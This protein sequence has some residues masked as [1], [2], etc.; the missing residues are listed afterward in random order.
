M[1]EGMLLAVA[2]K[3]IEDLGSWAFQEIGSLWDVEA[4]LE[5]IKNT[6]ST[7]QAVLRDAAEQ[8]THS[9]QVKDWLE[10]LKD[11]VYEADDLLG[12]FYTEALQQGGI[13]GNIAKKVRG[14]FSTSNPLVLRREMSR[15][16][17]AMKQKLNA[18]A[19]DRK[20]F[21]L[22]EYNVGPPV[23]M[24]RE[25]TH[26]FVL[27]EKV[28]GREDDK[29]AIIKLLLEPNNEENVS[30]VPIVGIGGLGKTT[31]AQFVYNDKNIQEHFEL[32]MWICISDVFDV[33]MIIQKIVPAPDMEHVDRSMDELQDQLRKII[34][35]KKY[36]LVLDD[37]WNEDPHKWDSLKDLLVGGAKGSKIVI[38]TRARLV[39]EITC[40]T[41]IY[42]L[43]GLNEVQ[44][45]LLFKQIAFRKGQGQGTNN[46]RLEEIGREIV[47]KCQGIPLAI[48]SIGNVLRLE[49][50]EHKWLYVNNNILE[51]ATQQKNDIFPIL[52][53]SYDYLP[54]HLKSC[55]AFCS[56][57]PKDY[58]INKV[59]LVQLW[60]AQGFIRPSNKNQELEDVADEY[61]KDLLWRSFFEEVTNEK[62][63]LKYKMH[64]LIHD[65]A[66]LVARAECTIITLDRNN[67][68]EKTRHVSLPFYIGS[69]FIETLGL[70]VRAEK[71]RTC[72]L[73]FKPKIPLGA[74]YL[75]E[76][77][78]NKLFLSFRK[79]RALGLCGVH[80]E[81]VPDSI[82][83]LIHLT[84]LDFS[85]NPRI[86]TLPNAISRLWK[87][88]T[89]KFNDCQK[90]KELP[91]DIRFLVGLRH[92]ENSSC[93][94][95][96]HMP[97]GLG[98]MTCLQTLS[99]F[100]VRDN[101]ASTSGPI[102]SGLDELNSLNSLRGKLQIS[103]LRCLEDV[104]SEPNAA[105]L[106]AKQYLD[107]LSLLWHAND[108][109]FCSDDDNDGDEKLLEGLQPH[110]NLKFL[111]VNGYGGVRFSSWLSLLTNLVDLSITGC[112]RCQQ[113]PRLSQLH[114]LERL[115]LHKMEVLE[116]IS[117]GDINEEV[118]TSSF[119]P[120]LKSIFIH[121]CPKLKGWWRSS[122]TTDHQQ[123]PHHQSLPSFHH[124]S[125]L[126]VLYCPN[127]ISL[128]PFP[129][130]EGSLQLREVSLK[131]LQPTIAMTS[132]LPCS[133]SF[134]SSPFSK[135]KSMALFSIKDIEA[136]PDNWMSNLS[137]LKSL[138]IKGGPK[139]KSLSLAVPHL[140]SLERLD[141]LDCELFDSINDMG[142]DGTEWQH[143][144]CLS[145]LSYANVPNLKSIPSGLQHVTALR[146]LEISNCPNLTIF[147]ELTSVVYLH[148]SDSPNLTSIP[149]GISNLT[150]LEELCIFN[151]PNLKSLPDEMLSLKS[152][153]QL[154]IGK[155]PDLEIRCEKGIGEDWF[156]IAHIPIF[157]IRDNLWYF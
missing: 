20:M 3:I 4:E 128:P 78:L 95:L 140:T 70:L 101:Q 155:C 39:A 102:S 27:G 89:L 152:L 59:T 87:L 29:K 17:I 1:A 45:W 107:R 105:N 104:Y 122:S 112:K 121:N 139:L 79:L 43:K 34:N 25:E 99:L 10:K 37:V 41:S 120:S 134:L 81:R 15:K 151:C 125:D 53:L 137:S 69:S 83:K 98:Q 47:R 135:L 71:L 14:F 123:H 133:S 157:E 76:S 48:K 55:F 30:I 33:K 28:I 60:I 142:D 88:Q 109:Y 82:E 9:H 117:D 115:W 12:E 96:S 68:D 62:G 127:L 90:L 51:S 8:Q 143:L 19:E 58:E 5:N 146:K 126:F 108:H 23:S 97:D 16:I 75:D 80:I 56:L 154:I 91:R 73:T 84:Y 49:K 116:Y 141:I 92:L 86:E 106:R 40:P 67:F 57:F 46:P 147:P 113:L 138:R 26:S 150:S 54:S 35:Q 44:S 21:H 94:S 38:T 24:E 72:L 110:Q 11:A 118:P 32:K 111:S 61:F 132:S 130:L 6:V 114:S 136:L 153:Q 64:D 131:P 52:K 145:S 42:S 18:I 13:S 144:K 93:D 149:D 77:K 63:E 119:F 85:K 22:K 74:G 66:Q 156:K 100:V 7:I 2:Q 65:L 103:N 36:L 50:T 129:Y 31:L 124:L 148:I